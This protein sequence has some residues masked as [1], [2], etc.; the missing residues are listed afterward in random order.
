[1]LAAASPYGKRARFAYNVAS[2]LYSNRRGIYTAARTIGRAYRRYRARKRSKQKFSRT[3]FGSRVGT[4]TAKRNVAVNNLSTRAS[5]VLYIQDLILIP[6]T[7]TN[8]IDSR[9]RDVVNVKGVRC[10]F[11]WA[12]LVVHPLHINVAFVVPKSGNDVATSTEFFRGM[13]TDRAQDFDTSLSSVELSCL[14]INTDKYTILKH[15]RFML[16]PTS[17]GA[18]WDTQ[19]G[20]SY[21]KMK[22]YLRINRQMRFDSS[23][24]VVEDGRVYLLYWADRFMNAG[25][26]AS[27]S[28]A[29][30]VNEHHIVYFKEPK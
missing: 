17:G 3:N 2:G 9:Q 28:T 27:L 5:R 19:K 12:N 11:E 14:P 16:N 23:S 29:F 24:G 13:S 26:A 15:K 10:C 18:V 7:T 21:K 30:S 6:K 8:L 4:D 25:G 22:Y 1:M 20:A